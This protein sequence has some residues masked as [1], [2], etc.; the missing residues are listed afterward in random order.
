VSS[1]N[2]EIEKLPNSSFFVVSNTLDALQLLAAN[3][4][5]KFDIPVIGITG[6]NGKTVIKEWLY[7]L[8]NE[9]KTIVR[10][11]KSYNSQIGVPLSV[12]QMD[13]K[14]ELAIF[15]AGISEPEEMQ[16]LQSIIVPNIG[17]FYQ[18]WSG[19]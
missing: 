5:K 7:Y 11:P 14:D 2:A 8:M 10:S 6:S 13:Q 16:K 12:W 3:H 18:Y 9:D 17:N 15:E 1:L 4:R 19:T